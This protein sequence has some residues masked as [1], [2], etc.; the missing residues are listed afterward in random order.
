MFTTELLWAFLSI[1]TLLISKRENPFSVELLLKRVSENT[2]WQILHQIILFRWNIFRLTDFL[3][4]QKAFLLS[5]WLD[6]CDDGMPHCYGNVENKVLPTRD[7]FCHVE[8]IVTR[9]LK[10]NFSEVE[11]QLEN[12]FKK[13]KLLIF[14]KQKYTSFVLHLFCTNCI[15]DQTDY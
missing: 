4:G 8:K 5:R 9:F 6:P 12:I 11:I 14:V 13:T 1:C 15:M 2:N 10:L 7:A 3:G